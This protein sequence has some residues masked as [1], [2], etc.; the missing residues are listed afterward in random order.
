MTDLHLKTAELAL[1]NAI[2]E[3][4]RAVEGWLSACR[5]VWAFDRA[6]TPLPAQEMRKKWEELADKAF[7]DVHQSNDFVGLFQAI[8]DD[9]R[10]RQTTEQ[11]A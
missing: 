10:A 8:V 1:D 4:R 6:T 7:D 2:G 9:E 5:K 3:R 11:E